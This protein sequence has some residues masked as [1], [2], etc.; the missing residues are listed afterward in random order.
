MA[1]R[2]TY[3]LVAGYRDAS[4]SALNS[5]GFRDAVSPRAAENFVLPVFRAVAVSRFVALYPDKSDYASTA[6]ADR[7]VNDASEAAKGG[8]FEDLTEAAANA[9]FVASH[10][11]DFEIGRIAADAIKGEQG[12][13]VT[14]DVIGLLKEQTPTQVARRPLWPR[15]AGGIPPEISSASARAISAS[16]KAWR[17][18]ASLDR[19]VRRCFGWHRSRRAWQICFTD[20]REPLPWESLAAGVNSEIARRLEKLPP[21]I[22]SMPEQTPAPVRVEERL[23]KVAQVDNSGSSLNTAER[24]FDAWREPVIDHISELASSDFGPEPTTVE[25]VIDLSL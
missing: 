17:S 1:R 4:G 14:H 20:L 22:P 6:E 23:G 9:S 16:T 7:D 8:K 13:F 19:L 24:D 12:R 15:E 10:G 25:C 18:L 21:R 5:D 3:V 11:D 2:K